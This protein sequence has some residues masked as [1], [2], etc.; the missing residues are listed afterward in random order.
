MI[1]YYCH[2]LFCLIFVLFVYID[3]QG[4]LESLMLSVILNQIKMFVVKLEGLALA[5]SNFVKYGSLNHQLSSQN[6]A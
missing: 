4:L 2:S 5:L 1:V 3:R 6:N